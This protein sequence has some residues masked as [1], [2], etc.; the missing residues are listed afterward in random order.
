MAQMNL[1]GLTAT[2]G[3]TA[4]HFRQA[5]LQFKEEIVR[6]SNPPNETRRRCCCGPNRGPIKGETA[7]SR[8]VVKLCSI[9]PYDTR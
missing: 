5:A 4:V 3:M 6:A 7:E 8:L 2:L 9:V 1:K